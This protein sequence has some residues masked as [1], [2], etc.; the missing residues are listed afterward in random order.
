MNLLFSCIGKRGYVADFFRPHLKTGDR[1]IGTGNTPWTPGFRSCDASVIL[2]DNDKPEYIPAVLDLCERQEID[3]ILSFCDPDVRSLAHAAVQFEARG[4]R[5]ILPSARAAD[6][7]F[8][9]FLMFK[10]LTDNGIPT[11]RTALDLE[12]AARFSFPMFVKPRRGSGSRMTFRARDPGEL[13]AFFN[14]EPDM[15]I[16]EAALGEE[17]NLEICSDFAGEPVG[18]SL[19]RKYR[20]TLG[21]TEQ[22]ETFR[23]E[24]VLEFGFRF[25]RLLRATGPMD[26]DIIR[27]ANELVLLEANPRFGGGYPVSH[28]AGADFPRLIL[29]LIRH[30]RVDPHYGYATGVVMMKQLHI[31]GGAKESFFAN[32]LHL[33]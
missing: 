12:G 14:Y 19:W 4:I 18:V 30:G 33:A 13:N 31:I 28:L 26:I 9:K 15:I 8:D 20:S 23:D 22:A 2:P 25:S 10:F 6:L 16:Q 32:E 17:V 11:P 7:A 5:M 24:Q 29:D 1:I 27:T 3:A 21:E